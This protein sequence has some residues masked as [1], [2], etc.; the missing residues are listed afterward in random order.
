MMEEMSQSPVSP[1]PRSHEKLRDSSP[2]VSAVQ[3]ANCFQWRLIP[4]QEEYEEIRESFIQ[5]PWFC[6]DKAN[7][8]CQDP[9][10]IEYDATRTWVVDRPNI[11]KTPAGFKRYV[12]VRKDYSRAD[13]YYILPGG[14]KVRSR[15]EV[16][17]FLEANPGYRDAGITVDN[18]CFT[19]P[20]IMKE[21]IPEDVEVGSSNKKKM[22]RSKMDG[23]VD[24]YE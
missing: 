2:S 1:Y 20:K 16:E 3:C 13:T 18:F 17:S 11:P 15:T 19:T 22:K 14:K 4:T 12:H 23:F 9:S 5:K 7:M 6:D 10:D 24:E 8:T 21:T